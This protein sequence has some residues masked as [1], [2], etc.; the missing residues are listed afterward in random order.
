MPIAAR[1][2]EVLAWLETQY[3]PMVELLG[4]LVDT[5]SGS[6][7]KAGVDRAG[8]ILQ[9]H[10]QARGIACEVA[11]HPTA[12][13]FLKA[14]VPPA[15]GAANDHVLLLGHRDTVFPKGTAL[16]RPF[17]VEGRLAYGPGVSDMKAGS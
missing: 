9:E 17:R 16:A 7:D 4:R 1:E 14:S 8:R 5:D 13:F 10:L 12:G 11:D 6:L 2:A 3:Q 15:G